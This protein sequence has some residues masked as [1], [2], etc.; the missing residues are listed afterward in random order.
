ME[1]H[2][3]KRTEFCNT[4]AVYRAGE[5]RTNISW[6]ASA[7]AL[8]HRLSRTVCQCVSGRT[9]YPDGR[10]ESRWRWSCLS[11]RGGWVR[12]VNGGRHVHDK[13]QVASEDSQWIPRQLTHADLVR[14]SLEATGLFGSTAQCTPVRQLQ[15]RPDCIVGHPTRPPSRTVSSVA[16]TGPG[17]TSILS[18]DQA[19]GEGDHLVGA[20]P[21][22]GTRWRQAAPRLATAEGAQPQPT[23]R[24]FAS[25]V[26]SSLRSFRALA[27][28]CVGDSF[29]AMEVP[30]AECW[31]L[32]DR[33]LLHHEQSDPRL[34]IHRCRAVLWDV[35][36]L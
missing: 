18:L 14:Q 11:V 24:L 17:R 31:F 9:A 23:R 10:V 26:A 33:P 34:D 1:I 15:R 8:V 4:A 16:Q 7:V 12:A 5:A 25:A 32:Q 2:N 27:I 30:D 36:E 35:V 19:R 3:T 28:S 6:S 20:S 21:G 22:P 29:M 13:G